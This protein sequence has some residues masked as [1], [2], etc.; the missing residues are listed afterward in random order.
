VTAGLPVLA[1]LGAV[2]AALVAGLFVLAEEAPR[3]AGEAPERCGTAALLRGLQAARL[4]LLIAAGVCASAAVAW[5]TRSPLEAASAVL[6][7]GAFLYLAGEGVPRALAGLAPRLAARAAP[8][9][10]RALA[11]FAPLVALVAAV[12]RWVTALLPA[13]RGRAAAVFGPGQRDMLLGLLSLRETTV[14]EV[15]TPRL[16]I[17]ALEAGA[18]AR[19]VVEV[20]RRSEHARIP[21]YR[22]DL[23]N[24][25]GVL[26]AKDLTPAAAGLAEP[27][28]SWHDL[29][30]PAQFVPESKS[31][32]AQLRDFQRGPAHLAIVV[33]EFGGTSGLV[34]L[35]DILEE[36]VGEIYDEYDVGAEPEIQQE[37]TDRFWVDGRISLDDLSELLGA[38]FASEEVATVGGLIYAELG[39]VPRP[40][41]EL[42]IGGFRVVVEQVVRRR[43]RRVFF[44]RLAGTPAVEA[45]KEGA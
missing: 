33:D 12:E 18:G 44:E 32:A 28:A 1:A 3:P 34:T 40:G 24:I 9:G 21:V 30:R 41:E 2:A 37:G 14:A 6:L 22:D 27:P 7:A 16:D 38:E 42:R 26:Y 20:L 23:D 39:R 5:W 35:E 13:V 19:D 36:V 45:G 29:V 10:R 11:P 4:A 17:V 43:V 31:L 8:L 15:M 25:L